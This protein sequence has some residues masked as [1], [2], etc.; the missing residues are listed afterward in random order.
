L[1]ERRVTIPTIGVQGTPSIFI[2]NPEDNRYHRDL[3]GY[4]DSRHLL[5]ILDRL[6]R[7]NYG[8]HSDR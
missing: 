1:I 3:T 6:K 4:R 8:T 5:E 2:L 7:G